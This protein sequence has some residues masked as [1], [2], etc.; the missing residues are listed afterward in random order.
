MLK[1]TKNNIINCFDEMYILFDKNKNI[2][3]VSDNLLKFLNI[4]D[5]DIKKLTIYDINQ[6]D[7]I[8]VLFKRTQNIYYNFKMEIDNK[9]F[10]LSCKTIDIN[11]K[12][13]KHLILIRDI[14]KNQEEIINLNQKLEDV[15]KIVNEKTQFLSRV[16]HEIRTPLNGIIGMNEIAINALIDKSY[17][18]ALDSVKKVEYSSKYLLSIVENVLDMSRFEVGKF[19]V[20]NKNYD[21]KKL[22]DEVYA[23]VYTQANKKNQN[24]T[25]TPLDSINLLFD[26]IKLKQILVNIIGNSIKYTDE[27]G[28]ISVCT[29]LSDKDTKVEVK[30]QV[31][32]NGIGMSKEFLSHIFE[33]FAQEN[34]NKNIKGTGLG[35]AI[36]KNL[37]NLLNGNINYESTEGLGTSCTLSFVFD[38]AKEK[39]SLNVSSIENF[40]F[41]KYRILVAEDNEINQLVI[42]KHLSYFN[43]KFDIASD[44]EEALELFKNKPINYYD[45]I[46]MDIHMP[47]LDGIDTSKEIR[48]LQRE[49]SKIGIIA[50]SA[51]TL[52]TDIDKFLIEGL[53]GHIAKPIIRDKMIDTIYKM[54]KKTN[55]I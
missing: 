19:V 8:D 38:K 3:N 22:L 20:E 48:K 16:S 42:S 34:K 31:K 52:K 24:L 29:Q 17:D 6:N 4:T 26:S 9:H 51:D 41:S 55:K 49:D 47:N 39:T 28:Q 30:I 35:L 7:I 32:D 21:L 25:F 10:Y 53:D 36:T 37:V 2:C 11:Y 43:F 45:L 5:N 50:L 46:L 12:K 40:D 27:N 1:K 54:L 23:I 14:T 44:G 13:F 18:L 15:N 33:P